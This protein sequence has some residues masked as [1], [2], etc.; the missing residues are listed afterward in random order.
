MELSEKFK[1]FREEASNVL[2]TLSQAL[3]ITVEP[4]WPGEH[5]KELEFLDLESLHISIVE[6]HEI[7]IWILT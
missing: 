5:N 2:S 7:Y 6:F 1:S 3:A 4:D